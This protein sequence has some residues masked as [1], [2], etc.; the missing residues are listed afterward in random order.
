MASKTIATSNYQ[1]ETD[2]EDP[3]PV[4]AYPP[5]K[6]NFK[7]SKWQQ[8]KV[9]KI[10]DGLLTGRIKWNAD[11]DQEKKED[12]YDAWASGSVPERGVISIAPMKEKPPTHAES[13]NPPKQF[14]F[15]PEEKEEW[16]E[17]DEEDRPLNYIPTNYDKMRKIP[18]YDKLIQERFQRCLDLYLC[19]RV[20]KKKLNIDPDTFV[21]KLPDPKTLKPFPT[22]VAIIYE[23]HSSPVQALA[24]SPS[25]DYLATGDETGLFAVW[26]VLS[27]RML[28][29]K[30][31]DSSVNSID[32][33]F[34]NVIGIG[35][36]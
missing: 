20:K 27:S 11:D 1:F 10:L 30:Q 23:G 33:S 35:C 19:P 7:P 22:S 21:P 5:S 16:E 6:K 24:V 14:L 32:W 28:F 2:R 3:F 36:G 25:G 4:N 29:S 26:E 34:G 13:Y 18:F 17:M 12:I 8:M 9:N 15:T 31:F